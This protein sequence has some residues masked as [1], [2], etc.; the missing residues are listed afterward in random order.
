MQKVKTKL[1]FPIFIS[2]VGCP[3]QCIYCNQYRITNLSPTY[4]IRKHCC[5]LTR[6]LLNQAS[7]FVHKHEN[8]HKEIA[9]F[10]GSF[11]CLKKEEMDGYFRQFDDIIDDKTCFRIS[12]RPD[13]ISTD[14][15]D[16][17]KSNKVNTI[18]LGVQSFSDTELKASKRG[19]DSETAVKS[20][21]LIKSHGF[22]LSV[23]LLIGLPKAENETY[24]DT[25]SKL[26]EIKPDFVRLYPLIVLKDTELE[27]LY[28]NGEYK[29]LTVEDAVNICHTF[30]EECEA[31]DIK[32]IKV[33]LHS[34]ITDE[35]FVAGPYHKNFGEIIRKL[36]NSL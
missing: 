13:A 12:T 34:D 26:K 18:E 9:F 36:C 3:F 5:R 14:I 35:S 7:S 16:F 31:N 23:Q 24:S 21:E 6:E 22:N 4:D 33:G 28:R 10:G 32:V 11:T 17:L 15:L 29:P 30:L 20:C 25:L 19:Y 27:G 1:I 2:H 8:K